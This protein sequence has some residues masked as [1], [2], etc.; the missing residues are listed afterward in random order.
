MA[1]PGEGI[2]KTWRNDINEVELLL[3]GSLGSDTTNPLN[4]YL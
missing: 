1:I 2:E 3:S 4:I